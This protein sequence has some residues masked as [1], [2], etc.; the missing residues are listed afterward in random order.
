MFLLI[1]INALYASTFTI[2]KAALLTG[3][4]PFFFI[5]LRMSIAGTLLLAYWYVRNLK[6]SVSVKKYFKQLL[7]YALVGI[8]L[9]YLTEFWV[10]SK[11]SSI[12]TSLIFN[13]SPFVAALLE[14][15]MGLGKLTRRKWGALLLGFFG[16]IPLLLKSGDVASLSYLGFFDFIMIVSVIAYSYGWVQMKNLVHHGF[17]PV[18]VNGFAMTFAGCISLILSATIVPWGTI[19]SW[20]YFMG[21]TLCIVLVGNIIAYVG[22]G[23]LLKY[24]SATFVTLSGL[25]RP[26]FVALYGFLFLHEVVT[27]HFFVSMSLVSAGLYIFYRQES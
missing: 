8:A 7:G 16:F 12:K 20:P 17:S 9:S 27:W 4:S 5:G 6:Q 25:V 21:L 19:S 13:C 15:A 1:F 22:M 3:A 11:I 26:L 14:Y 10:L 24:Y 18:W 23:F 2:G